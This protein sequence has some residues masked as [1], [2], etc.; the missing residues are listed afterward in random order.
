MKYAAENKLTI[1]SGTRIGPSPGK[2][3]TGR[4]SNG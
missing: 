1:V 3:T 4:S 2:R